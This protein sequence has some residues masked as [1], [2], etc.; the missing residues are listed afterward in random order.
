[1]GPRTRGFLLGTLFCSIIGG[2][3]VEQQ[4]HKK[5]ELSK[6][7]FEEYEAEAQ[8]LQQRMN[9]VQRGFALLKKVQ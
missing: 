5:I 4:L 9:L 8:L 7:R 1:M 3:A 6:Q 2:Y